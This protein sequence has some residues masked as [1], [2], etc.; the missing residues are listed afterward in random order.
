MVWP[1]T[2]WSYGKKCS[3]M[4]RTIPRDWPGLVP[5]GCIAVVLEVAQD[6]WRAFDGEGEFLV[7]LT[8]SGA[9]K[10]PLIGEEAKWEFGPA[11]FHT[12]RRAIP[13][14]S[15]VCFL[16]VSLN[17]ARPEVVVVVVASIP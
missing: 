10:V 17:M 15:N 14:E 12:L 13:T 2:L 8:T 7:E 6:R 1:R 9:I 3:L 11:V 16:D 5:Y 4:V